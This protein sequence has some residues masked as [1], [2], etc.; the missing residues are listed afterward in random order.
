MLARVATFCVNLFAPDD[1]RLCEAPLQELSRIPVCTACFE[2][3]PAL[4]A[5]HFCTQCHTPFRSAAG[6]DAGGRCGLCRRGVIAFSGAFS[7]GAYE[8]SL[9]R[10]I[11]LFKYQRITPLAGPLGGMLLRA[12]P[13]GERFDVLT[14]MPLH[15]TRRLARGFNQAELLARQV[16]RGTGLPVE[17]LLRRL[18]ATGSQAGLTNAGRRANVNGAFGVLHPERV[19]DRRILLVDD[20]LTTGATANACARELRAAGAA[21]VSILTLA[22]TDRRHKEFT[23]PRPETGVRRRSRAAGVA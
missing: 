16:A 10:L 2:A 7:F 18:R 20:V 19:K 4:D 11:H 6:L 5:E 12:L 17:R 13:R 3:I 21:R 15:W 22:R 1:C 14:P 8:G 23:L 9:A